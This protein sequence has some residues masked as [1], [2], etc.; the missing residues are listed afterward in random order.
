[1]PIWRSSLTECWVGLVFNSPAVGMIGHQRQ[2]DIDG[3]IARQ[4]VAELADRLEER[5]ALDIAD[6]AAD[7]AQHE[8]ETLVAVED[9]R[10]DRV[11]DVR[12]DLHRGAEVVAAP[13][14][15]R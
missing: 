7:L 5:Q 1:M 9:E 10:L 15:A 2:V 4:V 8:V 14:P 12:D 13:L 6:C 11:G 3:V